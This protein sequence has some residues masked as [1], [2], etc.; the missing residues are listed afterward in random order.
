MSF[1]LGGAPVHLLEPIFEGDP[2]EMD[3]RVVVSPAAGA[4]TPVVDAGTDVDA[5]EVIGAVRT[6][7][8]VIHVRTPFAG[9]LIAMEAWEGERVEA[10]Q[11]VAWLRAS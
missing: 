2:M 5:D 6:G 7:S 4:F 8:D 11:R 10:F 9:R 3:E 1:S